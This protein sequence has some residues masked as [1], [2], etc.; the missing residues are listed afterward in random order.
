MSVSCRPLSSVS[1]WLIS[2]GPRSQVNRPR[3]VSKKVT[4]SLVLGT[5]ITYYKLFGDFIKTVI[6]DKIKMIILTF[7]L[8]DILGIIKIMMSKVMLILIQ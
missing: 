5:N 2:P 1:T 6:T 3:K 7:N 8:L 4:Q